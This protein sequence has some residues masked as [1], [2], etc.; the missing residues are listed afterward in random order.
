M[1]HQ[2]DMAITNDYPPTSS[3]TEPTQVNE[4]GKLCTD[5]ATLGNEHS[6]LFTGL[7]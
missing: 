3:Q 7:A 2:E 5:H 4:Q 1:E 6:A